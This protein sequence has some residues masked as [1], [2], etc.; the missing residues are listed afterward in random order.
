MLKIEYI[1]VD[2]LKPYNRNNKKHG[3]LDVDNIAKSIEKYGMNDP[4]GI[5]KNNTVIE[6]HGRLLACKQLGYDTVP[7]VRLDHL[8]DKERREYAI[9]HNKTAELAPYDFV[10][11]EIEL[12]ELDF[13]D[14]DIDLGLSDDI[15][16]NNVDD[17]SEESYAPP[18]YRMLECPNCHHKDRDIH[19]KKVQ[20]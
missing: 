7:C 18:E 13:S 15:D 3:K 4:I 14:F 1:A 20:Q 17:L 5:W 10:N 11:L 19:F 8:S 16:W 9:L 6:G 2:D 12:A